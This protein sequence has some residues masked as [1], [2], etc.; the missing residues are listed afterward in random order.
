VADA[1]ARAEPV[2][3]RAQSTHDVASL[4][5]RRRGI[6]TWHGGPSRLVVKARL[7]KNDAETKAYAAEITEKI[8]SGSI[9]EISKGFE[10][11]WQ[12]NL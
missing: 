11:Y 8:A 4:A 9:L 5:R 1:C 7:R 12:R 10:G 2:D 6:E 3:A